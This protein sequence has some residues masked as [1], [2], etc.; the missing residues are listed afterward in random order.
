MGTYDSSD[1]NN[2]TWF[3]FLTGTR[4]KDLRDR[5]AEATKSASTHVGAYVIVL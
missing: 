4:T 3:G 5:R 1:N 2:V